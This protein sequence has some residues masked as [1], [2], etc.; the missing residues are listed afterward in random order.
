MC[1][2]GEG[3]GVEWPDSVREGDEVLFTCQ[4]GTR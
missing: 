1:V 2:G 4:M 3:R